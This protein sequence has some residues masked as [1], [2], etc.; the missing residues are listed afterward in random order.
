M[1]K[2]LLLASTVVFVAGSA[3][4]ADLPVR[5]A[6]MAP[7]AV[8]GTTWG[9]LY[10][11]AHI[12]AAWMNGGETAFTPWNGYAGFGVSGLNDTSFAG[13]LQAGYNVQ[14]GALVYGL[15]ADATMFGLKKWSSVNG[16]AR[17]FSQSTNWLGTVSG[18]LGYAA[19]NALLFVKGGVA[20]GD[21]D[22][23][24]NQGG[25][26]ISGD[27]LRWGWS[28]GAGVEYALTRNLSAKVEYTY[29]GFQ[30]KNVNLVGGGQAWVRAQNDVQ[31]VKLGLNYRFGGDSAIVAKY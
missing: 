16:P 6:P 5:T 14:R 30:N 28:L 2:S 11:G 24:H 18:R 21:F 1:L 4:A 13:G 15:E 17:P 19:G 9:G 29:N 27:T 23:K 26:I 8:S 25:T 7:I 10:V 20:L 31:I 12:G 3:V 22:Y